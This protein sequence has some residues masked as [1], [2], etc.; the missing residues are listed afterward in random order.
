METRKLE[1]L[2]GGLNN[3]REVFPWID[4]VCGSVLGGGGDVG[5]WGGG[6]GEEVRFFWFLRCYGCFLV[7]KGFFV[8]KV[9]LFNRASP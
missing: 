4:G 2:Q 7:A 5:C 1:S 3:W 9:F 8:A 6:F